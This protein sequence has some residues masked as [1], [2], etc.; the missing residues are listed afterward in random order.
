MKKT[1]EKSIHARHISSAFSKQLSLLPTIASK[2]FLSRK[3]DL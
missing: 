3:S 1:T 2:N